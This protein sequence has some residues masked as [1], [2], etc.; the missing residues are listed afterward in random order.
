MQ[1]SR[2]PEEQGLYSP[3]YEHDACGVGLLVNIH[4][5]KSHQVVENA[6]QV[7][8]HMNHR[9]A[10]GA[11]PNTGDGCRYYGADTSR[12]YSSARYS[13]SRKRAVMERVSFFCPKMKTRR[14]LFSTCSKVKYSTRDCNFWRLVMSLSTVTFSEKVR[15]QQNR[16]SSKYSSP[17]PR[18]ID[19]VELGRQ[20][21]VLRKKIEARV[22]KS[23]IEYK[24][25][26]SI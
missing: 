4:G 20:L 21:Y 7:L 19:E 8:E 13:C 12:V 10:E 23:D 9:G 25:K 16:P 3:A 18:E 11:D 1:H 22:L 6:L 5:G 15:P 17:S 14:L 24:K 2:K 26:I